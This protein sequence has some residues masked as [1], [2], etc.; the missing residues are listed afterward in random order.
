MKKIILTL[1]ICLL[2]STVNVCASS[3]ISVYL[4]NN[5]LSFDVPPTEIDGRIMVPMRKIFES[6]GAYVEW[7]DE[8]QFICAKKN[9]T[10]IGMIID[11][12]LM[13]VGDDFITLDVPP[14]LING[15]TMVPVRA[16]AESLN[17]NVKWDETNNR[18]LLTTYK[19][20]ASTLDAYNYLKN[21]LLEN[22]TAFAE[23]MYIGRYIDENNTAIEIR[24]Y[25]E[26]DNITL[27]YDT[28]ETDRALTNVNISPNYDNTG[29]SVNYISGAKSAKISGFI[30]A[31]KYSNN[32][33]LTYHECTP[34]EFGSKYNLIEHTRQRINILLDE[35]NLYLYD[36]GLDVSLYSLGFKNY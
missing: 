33:P 19:D 27:H 18:V 25:P 31:Q 28:F 5:P 3:N 13:I 34:G 12:P 6:L 2:V 1:I 24:Y 36:K 20:F 17:V 9:D 16:I 30:D 35:I 10:Y 26:N 15:R 23:Y 29:L 32:Y 11:N 14:K 22:G 4:N 7:D 8:N 21:Y